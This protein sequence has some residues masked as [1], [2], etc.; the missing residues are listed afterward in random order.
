MIFKLTLATVQLSSCFRT[1]LVLMIYN[2]RVER[3]CFDN[4]HQLIQFTNRLNYCYH[5]IVNLCFAVVYIRTKRT[6]DWFS[7][8][9]AG[10]VSSHINQSLD[11]E[12]T[13]SHDQGTLPPIRSFDSSL[14]AK[15]W[16][17]YVEAQGAER[18][19]RQVH[20]VVFICEK[21]NGE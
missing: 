19:C 12:P 7:V 13:H 11:S 1:K 14:P 9:W 18:T 3:L 20:F 2:T 17:R 4:Y 5:L 15:L 10:A 16:L 21:L 8:M 6:W